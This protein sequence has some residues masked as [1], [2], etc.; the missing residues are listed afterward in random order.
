V[1]ELLDEAGPVALDVRKW[2]LCRV[3]DL[4][5][6]EVLPGVKAWHGTSEVYP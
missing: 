5:G 6:V 2:T 4:L 1:A 3:R